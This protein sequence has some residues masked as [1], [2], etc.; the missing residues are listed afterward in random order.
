MPY[1]AT[2]KGRRPPIIHITINF[3]GFVGAPQ[4]EGN[5]EV[6]LPELEVASL[7]DIANLVNKKQGFKMLD[8]KTLNKNIVRVLLDG[9]PVTATEWKEK[10]FK[11]GASLSVLVPLMGG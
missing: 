10:K 8:K 9:T 5:V 4:Q 3:A 6:D 11:D 7:A 1:T 2:S